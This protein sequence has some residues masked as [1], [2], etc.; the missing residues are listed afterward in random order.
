MLV[1]SNAFMKVDYKRNEL[2]DF[3]THLKEL[4][5]EQQWELEHA[6]IGRGKMYSKRSTNISR[7]VK[8][9]GLDD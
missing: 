5:D 7:R 1:N 4:I 2:P 6:I 8:Q 3:V 9:T